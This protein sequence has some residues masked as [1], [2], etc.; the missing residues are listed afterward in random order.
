[1]HEDAVDR[2]LAEGNPNRELDKAAFQR[3][4]DAL[5]VSRE[6]PNGEFVVHVTAALALWRW[7]MSGDGV[8]SQR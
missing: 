2:S 4:A 3:V 6:D 8:A 7:E 1:M 5:G